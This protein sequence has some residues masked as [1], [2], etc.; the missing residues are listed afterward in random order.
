ML[1]ESTLV[2]EGVTLAAVVQLVVQ[3]LVDLSGGTVLDEKTAEDSETTHPQDLAGHTGVGRTLSLT[4][5]TVSALPPGEVQIAGTGAGVLGNGLA[6]DEAIGEELSDR[7]AGVGVGDLALLVGVEP[8]LALAAADNRGREAL[9]GAQVDPIERSHGQQRFVS[10]DAMPSNAGGAVAAFVSAHG[11][12]MTTTG[13][14]ATT[15][16]RRYSSCNRVNEDANT[17]IL[18]IG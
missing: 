9:L 10:S 16:A 3:V 11:Q 14:V 1:N 7:L 2:L 4:V 18:A 17:H 13:L 12:S 15:A 5:A 6:D 8:D